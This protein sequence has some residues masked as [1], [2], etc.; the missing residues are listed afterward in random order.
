MRWFAQLFCSLFC[1]VNLAWADEIP[2]DLNLVTDKQGIK[3]WT[4]EVP[5]SSLY[6]FKAVTTVKSSL[7]GLV[8]LI[9]D[10]EN[11]SRWLY[12][13]DSIDVLARND[14]E[15]NFT[16]RVVTDFPWPFK[17]REALVDV[18]IS[19]D[20]KTGRVRIDSNESPN[21]ANYPVKSCCLR[22]PVVQGY[23]LFKPLAN[24]M[25]EVTMTGHAHPGGRI[26]TSIV[27]LLIQEHPYNSL[28][29]L[30]K[31]ISDAKYQKMQYPNIKEVN[32]NGHL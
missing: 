15:Q 11:A 23:W 9:T 32:Q 29:G 18:R 12:R 16:I 2:T 26:P 30:R 21:A 14:N 7:S 31:V 27:N 8:G 13:T 24:G 10:T 4:Y 20:A 22:M 17:D 19:Q 1:L 25:V 28:R 3:I 5:K 6:G